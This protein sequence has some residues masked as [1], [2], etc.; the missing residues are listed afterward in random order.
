VKTPPSVDETLKLHFHQRRFMAML[1]TKMTETF[2]S[3]VDESLKS[4]NKNNIFH[5]YLA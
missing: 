2:G 1:F 4:I 3:S 5:Q